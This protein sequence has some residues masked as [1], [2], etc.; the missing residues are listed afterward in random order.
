MFIN[1]EV[2]LPAPVMFLDYLN[3]P[4]EYH[5]KAEAIRLK[6]GKK[7]PPP[8]RY[9]DDRNMDTIKRIIPEHELSKMIADA[10]AVID[11]TNYVKYLAAYYQN[12]KGAKTA[13][14]AMCN[15]VVNNPHLTP[16]S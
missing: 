16:K 3:H 4:E 11:D 9:L 7:M 14:E 10:Q 6:A 12:T 13:L 15:F 5:Q 8:F 1:T 2:K